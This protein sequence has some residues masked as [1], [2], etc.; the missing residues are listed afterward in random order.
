[1]TIS[2]EVDTT[3]K[4]LFDDWRKSRKLICKTKTENLQKEY[5]GR[6]NH[7][8][9]KITAIYRLSAFRRICGFRTISD[10]ANSYL[11]KFLIG[12][13]LFSSDLHRFHNDNSSV[14]PTWTGHV[15]NLR[16]MGHYEWFRDQGASRIKPLAEIAGSEKTKGILPM[17]YQMERNNYSQPP[18]SGNGQM[19]KSGRYNVRVRGRRRGGRYG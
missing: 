7:T 11:T 12:D 9:R 3:I 14:C 8:D 13:S 10:E 15:R 17:S 2:K 18:R 1:M 4:N 6:S 5:N 16:R 19:E